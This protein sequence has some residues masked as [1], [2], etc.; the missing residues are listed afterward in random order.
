MLKKSSDNLQVPNDWDRKGLPAWTY[1]SSELLEVEKEELFRRHWQLIC[2]VSD[3]AEPGSYMTMDMVGERALVMRGHDGVIRAFH[4][5]CRHRGSRLVGDEHGTC[6]S[7][8]ICP[9]HGWVYNTDGTLRGAASPET[10]PKLDPVEWGLK[11]L[12]MEIWHGFIFIRFKPSDQP[13]V[14]ELFA[15]FEDEVAPYKL[16]EL[17]PTGDPVWHGETAVNYKSVRDVDNEGYHVR[18]AHP[19]LHDLYGQDYFDEN[20]E[21]GTSRSVGNF[22]AG[23]SMLW[24][25]RN[26]RKIVEACDWLPPEQHGAWLYYGM[27]PNNVISLYPETVSFYQE[28]PI[29]ATRTGLRSAD[30]KRPDETRE[31]RAARYLSGRIDKNTVEEDQQLTIWSC[32]ANPIQWL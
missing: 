27:F 20:W 6:P 32:E 7:T 24:S 31:M 22:N 4:N 25:V 10:F 21:D 29:S 28:Y 13:S 2:H 19:G 12:E 1:F 14:A 30:Y 5:L 3:I 16:E 9:Y 18:M 15:R 23:P 26:Y 17:Q 8:V 11:P